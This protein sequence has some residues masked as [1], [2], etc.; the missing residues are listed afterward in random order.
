MAATPSHN[1]EDDGGRRTLAAII[2]TD[3]AGYSTRMR[4]DEE[5]TEARARADFQAMRQRCE[6]HGGEVLQQMGDGL[7]LYFTSAIEALEAAR[8]MQAYAV[9]QASIE[10]EAALRH[11]IGIHLGDV[12][13]KQ[14]G[15]VG[16]GV[17]I[18]ARLQALAEPNGICFSGAI[19]DLT[20]R[21]LPPG[22]AL[23]GRK[24]L[25][26]IPERIQVYQLPA[27]TAIRSGAAD[28]DDEET[29][30]EYAA[31]FK[32]SGVTLVVVA[33]LVGA[34]LYFGL[35]YFYR[36]VDDQ[37]PPA[38]V[39]TAPTAEPGMATEPLRTAGAG[40]DGLPSLAV[41]PFENL[42]PDPENAYFS[43]GMTE[44]LI[45]ALADL[46]G[47]QVAARTSVFALRDRNLGVREIADFLEVDYIVEGSVRRAGDQV[48]ITAQLIKATDGFHLWSETFQRR[49]EDIF[50]LQDEVSG[51][52]AGQ[53]RVRLRAS[54]AIA[55]V[56]P[57][58]NI[59][60]YSL[61][62]QGR[63]E[64]G[65]RTE[66]SIGRALK[67]L[68][69]AVA[70]DPEFA[71]A[72]ASL[73]NAHLLSQSYLDVPVDDVRV[74]ARAAADRALELDPDMGEVYTSLAGLALFVD[75]K[76]LE[77][78]ELFQK[79]IALSP[80]YAQTY[81]WY[82]LLLRH[83]LGQAQQGLEMA[84]KAEE[85]DPLSPVIKRSVASCLVAVGRYREAEEKLERLLRLDFGY[86]REQSVITDLVDIHMR[87]GDF[88]RAKELLYR[89]RDERELL[90]QEAGMLANILLFQ[91][92]P[93]EAVAI[94]AEGREQHPDDP[95]LRF[96]DIRYHAFVGDEA[97][98]EAQVTAFTDL[99]YGDSWIN[100]AIN[101]LF[102]TAAYGLPDHSKRAGEQFLAHWE[103]QDRSQGPLTF[104]DPFVPMIF[105]S[106][107]ADDKLALDVYAEARPQMMPYIERGPP[108]LRAVMGALDA[109]LVED[110]EAARAEL[111]RL[112]FELAGDPPQ[113]DVI[114]NAASV[115]V[116]L[117]DLDEA[118]ATIRQA[119]ATG[120]V[121]REAILA[122]AQMEELRNHPPFRVIL[123]DIGA[124][125]PPRLQTAA[126]RD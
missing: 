91:G 108:F 79:A 63:Y 74:A 92:L 93:E 29:V 122:L 73:A 113:A 90:V 31:T 61:Y 36:A 45:N 55:S 60:A 100:S 14:S 62:L 53:L 110:E 40:D 19:F 30:R 54:G 81:H 46:E 98:V 32:L 80:D 33:L 65:Q 51:A 49:M 76:P 35:K 50:A 3:I 117:D 66:D 109:L 103:A 24:E 15:V 84:L 64:L 115:Y 34:G 77:A 18:A 17:N 38:T 11:R 27:S 22:V 124:V 48:R 39:T 97:A 47:L 112:R 56:R 107:M 21:R 59:E 119:M 106:A 25:K 5:G 4:D 7:L 104:S 111:S 6:E 126:A 9:E 57:T 101:I 41:L 75:Q 42:S 69:E 85:L 26:G 96:S 120:Y 86:A 72:W 118:V 68:D 83:F 67:L 94:I 87:R 82:S 2:F 102:F 95:F 58:D 20:Q 43:D 44:E 114:L 23:L 70:L 125:L 123:R 116:A 13:R 28:D 16:D 88:A 52:I 78:V 121:N 37:R 1:F 99:E 71:L 12:M 89:A 105:S 8:A 10:G